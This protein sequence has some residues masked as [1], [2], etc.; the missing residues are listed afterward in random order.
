MVRVE[1]ILWQFFEIMRS[2][3]RR[4]GTISAHCR[5]FKSFAAASL[6]LQ[7]QIE[8]QPTRLARAK[9]LLRAGG[10]D[11]DRA[12]TPGVIIYLTTRAGIAKTRIRPFDTWRP[13][14]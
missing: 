12:G 4:Y 14:C 1:A 2:A 5:I 8:G 3:V 10:A 13:A 7:S 6:L 11:L 9:S